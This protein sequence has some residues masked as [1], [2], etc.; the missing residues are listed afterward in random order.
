MKLAQANMND[1]T[2]IDLENSLVLKDDSRS[3]DQSHCYNTRHW[4]V[5][6]RAIRIQHTYA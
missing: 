5:L 2:L 3:A 4:S 1:V 6:S